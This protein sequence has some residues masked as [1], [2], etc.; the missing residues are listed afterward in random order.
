MCSVHGHEFGFNADVLAFNWTSNSVTE[1]DHPCVLDSV[2]IDDLGDEDAVVSEGFDMNQTL[3]VFDASLVEFGVPESDAHVVSLWFPV[4]K[5]N[6]F[7]EV[8]PHVFWLN[9]GKQYV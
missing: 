7:I 8:C 3:H 5:H 1:L 6:C 2:G 4:C 9:I